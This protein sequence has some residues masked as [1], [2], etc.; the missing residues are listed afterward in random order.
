[1][2]AAAVRERQA[3]AH[4]ARLVEE[5]RLAT[6]RVVIIECSPWLA[7][8][9]FFRTDFLDRLDAHF[10][11]AHVVLDGAELEAHDP[12]VDGFLAACGA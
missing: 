7:A 12:G 5:E 6:A 1:V 8:D 9:P 10:W 2:H 3:E 11:A 4:V